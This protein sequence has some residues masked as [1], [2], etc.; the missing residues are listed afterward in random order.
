VQDPPADPPRGGIFITRGMRVSIARFTMSIGPDGKFESDI[1]VHAS[2][3]MCPYWLEIAVGHVVRAEERHSEVLA[4]WQ[5]ADEGRRAKSLEAEF[6]SSMQA[7]SATGIA[8]DAFYARVKEDVQLPPDLISRWRANG[9]A[10]YKQI[11]EVLRRAFLM[12]ARSAVNLRQAVKEVFKFR[13]FAVHPPA[14]A[15]APV[16]YPELNTA[17]E[18]RIEAF[19]AHNARILCGLAI[20]IVAQLLENPRLDTQQFAEYCAATRERISPLLETWEERYGELFPR[21]PSFHRG[22]TNV[23]ADKHFSDAASP[24]WL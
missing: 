18:W 3:D 20:S 15:R 4:A 23:A 19:R 5:T 9:T 21:P 12:N 6:E 11:A 22:L 8:I 14:D 2:L 24:Q 10:R 16:R 1:A 13:D 17:A 7:I